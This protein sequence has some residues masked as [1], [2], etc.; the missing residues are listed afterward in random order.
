MP[1][2]VEIENHVIYPE[3]RDFNATTLARSHGKGI[4]GRVILIVKT[5]DGLEGLGEEP[6]T[7][8]LLYLLD[9]LSLS[10]FFDLFDFLV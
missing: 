5:D 8:T 9:L 4:Q 6:K 10:C 7:S 3:Y 1:R 2:I